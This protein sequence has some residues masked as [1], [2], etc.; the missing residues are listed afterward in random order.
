MISVIG[1]KLTTA[2]C[3]SRECAE[4]IGIEADV[5][6]GAMLVQESDIDSAVSSTID[7]VAAVGSVSR[8]TANAIFDWFGERALDVARI[9]QANPEWRS[10]LCPHG[11]HTVAEAVYALNEE[12]A[13]TLADVLL[14]RVPVALGSCWSPECSRVAAQKIAAAMAWGSHRAGLEL[15]RFEEEREAFLKPAVQAQEV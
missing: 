8:E 6:R 9:L 10:P 11:K 13:V 14:R 2:G 3:V 7:T 12:C 5:K 4:K 1:G 15:E